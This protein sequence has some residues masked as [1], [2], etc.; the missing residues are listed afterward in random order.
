MGRAKAKTKFVGI[1]LT[2]EQQAIINDVKE[3]KNLE[4]ISAAIRDVFRFAHVFFD[5]RLTIEKAC[6][7]HALGMLLNSKEYREVTPIWEI[8]KTVPQLEEVLH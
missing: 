3:S 5:D 4:S 8:L 7:P 6:K 2:E 1:R